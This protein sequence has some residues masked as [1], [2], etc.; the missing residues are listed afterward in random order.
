MI[1]QSFNLL[2]QRTVLKNVLFP[3][4]IAKV[5]KN[6]AKEKAMELCARFPIYPNKYV[7]FWF[8]NISSLLPIYTV[9]GADV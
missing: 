6:V 4:E 8:A 7:E 1:F 3:L 5:E 2:Q 9:Y